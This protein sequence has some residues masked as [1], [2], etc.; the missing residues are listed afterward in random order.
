MGLLKARKNKEV[1][2]EE[3]NKGKLDKRYQ[4]TIS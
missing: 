1:W 4:N 3:G 2:G